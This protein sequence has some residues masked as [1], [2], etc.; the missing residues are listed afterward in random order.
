M[1]APGDQVFVRDCSCDDTSHA[2]LAADTPL[3][4][5][6]EKWIVKNRCDIERFSSVL[7]K[8]SSANPWFLALSCLPESQ[9]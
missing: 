1:D 2:G 4:V 8:R 3:R 9:L 5:L 6:C 7:P